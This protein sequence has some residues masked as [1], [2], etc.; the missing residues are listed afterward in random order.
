MI[1]IYFDEITFDEINVDDIDFAIK[2]YDINVD[3]VNLMKLYDFNEINFV[4]T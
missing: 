4:L 3:E 1:L 2:F